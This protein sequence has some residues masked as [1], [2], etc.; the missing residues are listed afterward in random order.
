MTPNPERGVDD[1]TTVYGDASPRSQN[2]FV[3]GSARSGTTWV[4][5]TLGL[6]EGAVYLSE[7]DEAPEIPFATRARSGMGALPVVRLGEYEDLYGRLWDVAFGSRRRSILNQVANRLY[8]R[9]P[10][11]DK[12]RVLTPDAPRGSLRLRLGLRLAQP[13]YTRFDARHRIVRSVQVPLALE[14]VVHRTRPRVVLVRRHPLDVIA[15][16]AELGFLDSS[17]RYVDEDAV[18]ARVERWRCMRRPLGTDSFAN[19]AWLVGFEMSVFDEVAAAHP[20]FITVD[21]EQ[22]CVDP[23]PQLRRLVADLGLEWTDRCADYLRTSNAAGAG[24]ETKRVTSA[25]SGKWQTRLS[26]EQVTVARNLLAAFPIA[27]RYGDLVS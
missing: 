8:A 10:E 24:F 1:E 11:E 25:Q 6:T 7:P 22:L 13:S 2:V 21:H 27:S 12:V 20:E 23:E 18:A 17:L 4:A 26:E 16:R 19:L 14:W 3:V 15:S 9:V 5:R